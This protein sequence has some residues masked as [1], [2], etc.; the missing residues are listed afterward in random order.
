MYALLPGREACASRL[1]I[2]R[3]KRAFVILAKDLRL[4]T[5]L[6]IAE[7]IIWRALR[8]EERSRAV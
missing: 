7:F 1:F 6:Y 5:S 8:R 2:F 3:T 4:L